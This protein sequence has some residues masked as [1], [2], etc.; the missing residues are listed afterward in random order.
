MITFFFNIEPLSLQGG[1]I[2]KLEQFLADHLLVIGAVGIGVACLQVG[3]IW[4]V[5]KTGIEEAEY[6]STVLYVS[7]IIIL[8]IM[9]PL[10][11]LW[12]KCRPLLNNARQ[13]NCNVSI[14][15]NVPSQVS[16]P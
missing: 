12:M 16:N 10:L 6:Y 5:V 14:T 7:P 3:K 9:T 15:E 13:M 1:C 11:P 8:A 2:T 4:H